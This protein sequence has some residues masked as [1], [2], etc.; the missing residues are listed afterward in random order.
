MVREEELVWAGEER[1]FREAER[2]VDCSEGVRKE[3]R[4][5]RAG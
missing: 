2:R 3:W 1:S 4:R 5:V